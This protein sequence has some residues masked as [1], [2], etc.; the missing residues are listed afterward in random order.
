MTGTDP[1]AFGAGG[2]EAAPWAAGTALPRAQG[3]GWTCTLPRHEVWE[4]AQPRA[5]KQRERNPF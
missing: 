3:D 1:L 5:L 2:G 4:P